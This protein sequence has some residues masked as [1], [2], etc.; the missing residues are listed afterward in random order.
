MKHAVFIIL[1]ALFAD[2]VFS[3]D[4]TRVLWLGNSLIKSDYSRTY[5]VTQCATERGLFIRNT[6]GN[7]QYDAEQGWTSVPGNKDLIRNGNW[8][9]VVVQV[10]GTLGA[11]FST[12]KGHPYDSVVQA[13]HN[14]DN[15]IDSTSA[16]TVFYL[17]W[18]YSGLKPAWDSALGDWKMP[19]HLDTAIVRLRALCTEMNAGMMPA[20]VGQWNVQKR[21]PSLRLYLDGVHGSAQSGYLSGLICYAGLTGQDPRGIRNFYNLDSITTFFLQQVAY[22]TV[23]QAAQT[24]FCAIPTMLPVI[25]SLT[26]GLS[27]NNNTLEQ[28]L[29]SDILGNLHYSN[30]STETGTN[31]LL[32]RS[33]TPSIANVNHFGRV[34][35]VAPGTARIEGLA[36]DARDTLVLTV[37]AS[38][39]QYDSVRIFPRTFPSYLLDGYQL[40]A[41]GYAFRQGQLIEVDFTSLVEWIS[42]DTAVFK[43]VNG[44]VMKQVALGG[45]MWA[46]I[47]KDGLT[48]TVRFTM[49]QD[50]SLLLRINFQPD[51]T[52]YSP[53]WKPDW[54]RAY[55]DS[56]GYGWVNTPYFDR[57]VQTD[58]ILYNDSLFITNTNLT[59]KKGPNYGDSIG[60]GTYKINCHDGDY[61]VRMGIGHPYYTRSGWVRYGADTL[62]KF[63]GKQPWEGGPLV[64]VKT[65]TITVREEQGILLKIYGDITYLV[66]AT[67]AGVNMD[68]IAFDTKQF[69]NMP[70]DEAPVAASG[71]PEIYVMPNP[72]NPTAT[73]RLNRSVQATLKIFSV[74]GKLMGSVL[75]SR[76]SGKNTEYQ[77]NATGLPSGLYV[78]EV[79]SG[80]QLLRKKMILLK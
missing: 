79:R 65:D 33:F 17:P 40:S 44:R 9:Y 5:E 28:Y 2:H 4:T 47:N 12:Y 10:F 66:V 37:I 48:D 16:K 25:D 6:Y 52:I 24:P 59:V 62:F 8:D 13:M 72:F 54:G 58:E 78:A 63:T 56:V 75:P 45:P 20:G 19:D 29:A 51:D 53:F 31:R 32:F 67:S 80:K 61:M 76:T 68:S 26:I 64:G 38:E 57:W 46:A 7:Y 55:T 74:N 69:L 34:V 50:L 41:K 42:S 22:Q 15:L 3:A 60:E 1:A 21:D 77:W 43:I 73:I 35:A 14:W 71:A 39:A 36:G 23:F 70:S 18:T 27:G 11:I 49:L 30:N